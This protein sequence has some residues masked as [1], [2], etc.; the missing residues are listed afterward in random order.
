MN[1]REKYILRMIMNGEVI[2]ADDISSKLNVHPRTIRNDLEEINQ[3]IREKLNRELAPVGDNFQ[4]QLTAGE[5]ELLESGIEK[6]DYY[7]EKLSA[8]ERQLIILYD[9]CSEPG[10]ITI[11]QVADTYFIS[12]GTVNTDL[13][14]L[15]I[16]T[17]G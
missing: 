8:K 12:R 15:F 5:R 3:Y 6:N 9:L 11:Q 1:L 16:N 2:S 13:V 10:Y 14:W 7:K 4:L 17:C